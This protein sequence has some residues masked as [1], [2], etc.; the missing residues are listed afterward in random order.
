MD[1]NEIM[2]LAKNAAELIQNPALDTYIATHL[3]PPAHDRMH[4]L[5][6]GETHNRPLHLIEQLIGTLPVDSRKAKGSYQ[7]VIRYGED[8]SFRWKDPTGI[9]RVPL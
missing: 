5:V 9:V 3:G 1:I 7:I 2:A 4:I 6:L 8:A